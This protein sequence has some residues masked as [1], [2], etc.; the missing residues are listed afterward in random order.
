[1][2]KLLI[3]T[4]IFSVALLT[5]AGAPVQDPELAIMNQDFETLGQQLSPEMQ[6]KVQS[7]AQGIL[8]NTSFTRPSFNEERLKTEIKMNFPDGITPLTEQEGLFYIAFLI[9]KMRSEQIF[10]TR[11][12]EPKVGVS[13]DSGASAAAKANAPQVQKMS[14]GAAESDFFIDKTKAICI[15]I[16]PELKNK[17][18]FKRPIRNIGER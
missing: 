8:D 2:K 10:E 13:Q 3:L 6:T 9:H 12:M 18:R 4:A 5:F 15:K 1:M 7:F 16:F 11:G 17:P 14:V